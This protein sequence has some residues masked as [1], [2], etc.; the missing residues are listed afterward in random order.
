M[1]EPTDNELSFYLKQSPISS[2][3]KYEYLFHD[4]PENLSELC[5]LIQKLLLHQFWI[6]EKK[7]YG[8]SA[9]EL[10]KSGRDLNHE[11]NLRSVE[12][13]LE[14]LLSL[15]EDPLTGERGP[16]V[17]AVG[18]CRDYA[19]LLV[20][21]LR[22]QGIP[23]RVRSGVARYFSKTGFLE[24]HFICEFWNAS[25]QRWQRVDPQIDQIQKDALELNMDMTDLPADQFLNAGESY[26]ELKSGK[27]EPKNIGVMEFLGWRYARYKLVSDLASINKLEILAWEGWGICKRINQEQLTA[28]DQKLLEDTA[29][30]LK[31]LS[32]Y[33]ECFNQAREIY[34]SHPEL[35]LPSNYQPYYMEL[36][37][38]K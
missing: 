11:I 15:D 1:Y 31:D 32:F 8:I 26:F 28:S 9:S 35:Q 12:E 33:P 6:L 24:D 23:A 18:N 4:L 10:R 16:E 13:I 37:Q 22:Y 19:T 3:G 17:R 29:D 20:S 36:P 5:L 38:F 27:V 14:Y 21:I 2:A 25:E 34:Q 30:I 7:H